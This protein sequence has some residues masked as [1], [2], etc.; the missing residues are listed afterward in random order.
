MLTNGG[1]EPEAVTGCMLSDLN[2]NGLRFS[3]A[4][5]LADTRVRGSEVVLAALIDHLVGG[6][7]QRRRNIKLERLGGLQIDNQRDFC[8]LL[9]RHWQA[10]YL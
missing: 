8:R 3:K 6:G 2:M 7:E 10:F 1:N 4:K 5:A 9:D